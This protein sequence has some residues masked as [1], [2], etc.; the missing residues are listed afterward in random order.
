MAKQTVSRTAL[1][2]AICR[3][4]EQYQPKQTRLF[5]DPVA[6]ELVGAPIKFLMQFA[7]MRNLT[8]RQTDAVADG[9]RCQAVALDFRHRTLTYSG[10]PKAL[11]SCPGSGCRECRLPREI[12]QA[13]GAELGCVRRRT[14]RSVPGC[15]IIISA[16]QLSAAAPE[17]SRWA[18]ASSVV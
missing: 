7:A 6:K 11:S 5:Y 2:T 9:C 18:H 10:F 3:L 1:G 4:I 13:C 12:S 14:H 8:V 15:A 16:F 17:P